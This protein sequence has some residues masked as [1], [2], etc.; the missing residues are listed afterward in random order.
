MLGK[1]E[2]KAGVIFDG[3]NY[4]VVKIVMPNGKEIPRHN[5]EKNTIIFSVLK[6]KMKLV[7]SDNTNEETHVLVPGDILRFS[8][9]NYISGAA[10][11]DSEM[12][13][14]IVKNI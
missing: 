11:E 7:L 13:V 6:G 3:E 5:H 1:V 10:L 2:N 12:N 8:G 9:D 14:T 4:K